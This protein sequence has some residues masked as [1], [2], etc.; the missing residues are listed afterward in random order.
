MTLFAFALIFFSSFLHV[1]WNV[2]SKKTQPSL[3]FYSI[4]AGAA[5]LIWLP[6]FI[7]SCHS[8]SFMPL[9]FWLLLLGSVAAEV[10]YVGSLGY[11]YRRGDISFVYPSV[12]ALPVLMIAF[13]AIVFH[14]GKV[15]SY[16][17]LGGMVMIFLGC[18]FM[19]LNTF[20]EFKFSK[21]FNGV[22]AFIVLG[23]L[24]TTGYTVFDSGALKI[25]RSSIHNCSTADTLMYLFFIE[26][27]IC[28]TGSILCLCFASQRKIYHQ[29]FLK[30]WYPVLAGICSS[31]SYMLVL[32]SMRYVTNVSYIHA[33]RQ[34]SLPL[35]FLV[36]IL[37]L[38]EKSS[39]VKI[40]GLSGIVIG[41]IMVSFG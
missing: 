17:A 29:L 27:G 14:L 20:R 41:L 31:I 11:A 1:S 39:K 2:I 32:V 21:Y 30:S 38:K 18:L 7:Y 15:P 9:R 10:L 35:G 16:W 23:A 24:G 28:I 40:I 3:A 37:L 13:F 26:F 19:P 6:F 8:L 22:S 5:S 25:M 33:F 34:M 36:G 12:R 4:M